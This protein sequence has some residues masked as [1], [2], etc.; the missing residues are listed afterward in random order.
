[1]NHIYV[2]VQNL[3]I[4]IRLIIHKFPSLKSPVTESILDTI[5]SVKSSRIL[6]SLFWIISESVIDIESTLERFEKYI[7][8][9]TEIENKVILFLIINFFVI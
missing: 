6:R 7:V 5:T 1:M 9:L 2:I 4:Y 8:E 3:F